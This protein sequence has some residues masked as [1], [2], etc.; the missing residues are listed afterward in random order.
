[1]RPDRGLL[2][3]SGQMRFMRLSLVNR[4]ILPT[5]VAEQHLEPELVQ[6]NRIRGSEPV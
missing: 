6:W 1:M 3:K 2:I 5:K 4:P